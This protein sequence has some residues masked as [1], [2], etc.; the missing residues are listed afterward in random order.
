MWFFIDFIFCPFLSNPVDHWGHSR[1]APWCSNSHRNDLLL[2]A[3]TTR[4]GRGWI[5]CLLKKVF[6]KSKYLNSCLI[7]F[8][9]NGSLFFWTEKVGY[10]MI[11]L[12]NNNIA[13]YVS[14]KNTAKTQ[15]WYRNAP[16]LYFVPEKHSVAKNKMCG[17]TD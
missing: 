17:K 12:E 14:L 5:C 9:Y 8:I 1:R 13:V 7:I 10:D 3:P 16:H 2:G 6:L 15:I 11:K 4:K